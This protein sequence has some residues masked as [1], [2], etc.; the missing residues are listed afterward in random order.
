MLAECLAFLFYR[1]ERYY[2]KQPERHTDEFYRFSVVDHLKS[3]NQ[4][5]IYRLFCETISHTA[6]ETIADADADADYRL[7]TMRKMLRYLDYFHGELDYLKLEQHV[8]ELKF[9]STPLRAVRLGSLSR[10]METKQL[11]FVSKLKILI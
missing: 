5:I 7:E 4:A 3:I 10:Q 1:V 8:E 11:K 6:F 9:E 2:S